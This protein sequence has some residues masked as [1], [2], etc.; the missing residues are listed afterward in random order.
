MDFGTDKIGDLGPTGAGIRNEEVVEVF[1]VNWSDTGSACPFVDITASGTTDSDTFSITSVVTPGLVSL[2][3]DCSLILKQLCEETVL[4]IGV[5]LLTGLVGVDTLTTVALS[6]GTGVEGRVLAPAGS[7]LDFGEEG[8]SEQVVH[9]SSSL[10]HSATGSTGVAI[11]LSSDLI[12][13]D[14]LLN[15]EAMEIIFLSSG[16]NFA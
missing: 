11:K 3:L 14:P 12:F 4:S 10:L 5:V 13:S 16:S 9:F 1:T 7:R 2:I 15:I 6:L 8:D